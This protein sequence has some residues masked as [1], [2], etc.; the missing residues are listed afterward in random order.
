MF[1]FNGALFDK[2]PKSKY[3]TIQ[4]TC[5]S[6]AM[7]AIKHTEFDLSLLGTIVYVTGM[8]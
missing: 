5:L 3:L 7:N 2:I 1:M 6:R 8:S 4:L